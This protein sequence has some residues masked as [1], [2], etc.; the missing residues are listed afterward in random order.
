MSEK[1]G[2]YGGTFNP[3]HDGHVS[4]CRQCMDALSL[5]R[6][7]VI[8]ANVPPHKQ[9]QELASGKER[10]EMLSLAFQNEKNVVVSD[11]EQK[12]QGKSYT[13]DT[14]RE[15][16]AQFPKAQ[17][18]LLVGSDMLSSFDKWYCFKEILTLATLVA[19]A[20]EKDE[21][22]KLCR[23]RERL[24]EDAE[25]ILILPVKE[26]PVSSTEV[27]KN[28]EEKGSSSHISPAV[29]AY[30]RKHHLYKCKET[31]KMD[32]LQFEQAAKEALSKKRYEHTMAVARL[33]GEL[34]RVYGADVEAA[35][36]AGLLHDISKEIPSDVQFTILKESGIINDTSLLANPNVYHGIT[37]FLT[38]PER[39][40]VTDEDVLNAIR[41]HTTGRRGMS[42]LEKIVYVADVVSY[43][44]TYKEAEELRERAFS[45]LDGVLFYAVR[46]TIKKLVKQSLPIAF[47]SIDCYN[48]LCERFSAA[49]Q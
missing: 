24:L 8:P 42:L 1:I 36:A 39:F 26:V 17:L 13:I 28:L 10:M 14:L 11:I 21:Y 35:K 3:V 5:D 31:K 34:A 32:L 19:G 12:R 22:A 25:R 33:S 49:D 44:R 23:E 29:L 15:I 37:A 7:I 48:E 4:L 18:F 38:V 47:D 2:I 20:R 30:I 45:D 40:S 46:F 27:R 41:Y 16:R 6:M 9:A 43:D